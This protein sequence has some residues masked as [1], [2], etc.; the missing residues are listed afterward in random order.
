MPIYISMLRGVNLGP[1]NRM[2][3][4]PLRKSLEVLGFE[5]VQTYIQS[6]NVIFRAAKQSPRAVSKRIEETVLADFG[7]AVPVITQTCEQMKETIQNNPFSK[8]RGIDVSKMHVTFLSQVPVEAALKKL[9]V[10]DGAD[11]FCHSG[12]A[13]YLH[14][15]N[16]YS[17]TKL[18]NGFFEKTLAVRATTR[19]WKTVNQLYKMALECA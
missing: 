6:G 3:M 11:E 9:A 7:F 19:N 15:R 2:K 17:E 14:C 4:E 1:H 10:A 12:E 18:S 5:Q 13:I 8:K 16:G